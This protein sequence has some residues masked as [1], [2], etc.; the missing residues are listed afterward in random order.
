MDKHVEKVLDQ[1]GAAPGDDL[2]TV[3][4]KVQAV[5]GMPLRLERPMHEWTGSAL[6]A[7][8]AFHE[9]HISLFYAPHRSLVYQLHC[10]YHELGHVLLQTECRHISKAEMSALSIPIEGVITAYARKL[11]P[12]ETIAPR[13]FDLHEID[14][15]RL[16][17]AARD[18]EAAEEMVEN[19]AYALAA[20]IR[21][22]PLSRMG[23]V[24]A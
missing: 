4:R 15:T 2:E 18:F 12:T 7:A 22:R 10:I 8:M 6:T 24:F 19:F 14:R 23:E 1:V 5:V 13:N 9:R 16:T 3:L 17:P 20:R 11:N 21:E